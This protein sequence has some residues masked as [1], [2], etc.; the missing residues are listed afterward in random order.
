M[1]QSSIDLDEP[2][3]DLEHALASA[4]PGDE[5]LLERKGSVIA[6]LNVEEPPARGGLQ[7]FLELRAKHA[8]VDD[9]FARDLERIREEL[10]KPAELRF[11]A[12]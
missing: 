5:V 10:N 11:R 12:S 3:L 2:G 9:E 7:R 4:A 1:T 6:R 8:P